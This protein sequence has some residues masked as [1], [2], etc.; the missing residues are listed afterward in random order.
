MSHD[1]VTGG[2]KRWS[3]N[4]SD[5]WRLRRATTRMAQYE[6]GMLV[7]LKASE[8]VE[9]LLVTCADEQVRI[10][11]DGYEWLFLLPHAARHVVTAHCD[12]QGRPVHWYIDVVERWTLGSDGFP[13]YDDLFLDVTAT[14][15]GRVEILDHDELEEALKTGVITRAQ[16]DTAWKEARR[17]KAAIRGGSF[18]P[19][20]QTEAFLELARRGVLVEPPEA[21]L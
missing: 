8:V 1:T 18:E 20:A 11:A 9:P 6:G 3:T 2:L 12:A 13:V 5:W 14:P 21:G 16:Y 10:L 7:H 15:S 19:V 4:R 17:I